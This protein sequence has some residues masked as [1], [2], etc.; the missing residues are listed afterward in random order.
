MV[1][2]R[3]IHQSYNANPNNPEDKNKSWWSRFKKLVSTFGKDKY[4]KSEEFLNAKVEKEKAQAFKI[5]AEGKKTLAE[6]EKINADAAKTK[7]ETMLLMQEV[8]KKTKEMEKQK[9][10][11]LGLTEEPIEELDLVNIHALQ[12][13][14]E[15]KMKLLRI[16]D[17]GEINIKGK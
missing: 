6:I 9:M 1:G 11:E 17:G 5:L 10:R 15:E 14:I 16:I 12:K 2:N 4:Q 13:E 7:A 3:K 8:M